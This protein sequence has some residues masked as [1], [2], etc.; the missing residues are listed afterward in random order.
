MYGL[1]GTSVLEEGIRELVNV[2]AP[3]AH[4]A[5]IPERV[6]EAVQTAASAKAAA[7]GRRKMVHHYA[8]IRLTTSDPSLP[9][10]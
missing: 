10:Q 9:V 6:I 4:R 7:R 3:A 5:K 2:L 8:H 1:L